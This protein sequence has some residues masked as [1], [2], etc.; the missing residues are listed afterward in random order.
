MKKLL[1]LL[2]AIALTMTLATV[3]LTANGAQKC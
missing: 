1:I 2:G 3:E